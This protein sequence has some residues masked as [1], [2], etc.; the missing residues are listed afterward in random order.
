MLNLVLYI[1]A[2]LIWGT[3]WYVI[4]LHLNQVAPAFSVAY[5]FGLA[6]LLLFAFCLARRL[7]LRFSPRDHLF[8]ALQGLTLFAASYQLVYLASRHLTSG[9]VAVVFSTIMIM[10]VFNLRL[11]LGRRMQWSAVGAG[12]LGLAGISLVFW[13]ELAAFSLSSSLVG[14]LVVLA[15]TYLASVGNIIAVRHADAGVPVA[16]ANAFGM[17]YGGLFMLLYAIAETGELQYSLDPGYLLPLLFLSLFGSIIVF[18]SYMLL[19]YRIGADRAAYSNILA[20][21][22]AMAVSTLFEGYLSVGA[23]C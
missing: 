14:A 1:T 18:G 11:F 20:P 22:L 4:T 16:Q 12:V 10:N 19:V 3:T 23:R 5:R 7:T 6:A 9:L 8:M 21:V 13:P 17:G 15:A 2:V